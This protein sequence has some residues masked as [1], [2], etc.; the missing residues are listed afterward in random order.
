LEDASPI[1]SFT[2][3]KRETKAKIACDATSVL[4]KLETA[5][6]KENARVRANYLEQKDKIVLLDQ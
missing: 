5:L 2:P 4:Q 1:T 6:R 3:I